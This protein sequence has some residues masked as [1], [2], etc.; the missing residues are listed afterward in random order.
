VTFDGVAV[1]AE[2]IESDGRTW[3]KLVA[4]AEAPE[5]EASALEINNRAAAWAFALSDLDADVLAPPL[6]SLVPG[7]T[8]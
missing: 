2:L 8:D 7:A 6:S 3:V 1:E 5:Q 4:R